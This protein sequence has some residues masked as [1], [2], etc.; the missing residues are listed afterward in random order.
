MRV[1]ITR[2]LANHRHSTDIDSPDTKV[3]VSTLVA[4]ASAPSRGTDKG[5]S[6]RS[7]GQ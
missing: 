7:R 6:V 1:A 5:V 2:R 3:E 4:P